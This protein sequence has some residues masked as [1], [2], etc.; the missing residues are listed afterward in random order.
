METPEK[1]EQKEN[2]VSPTKEPKSKEQGILAFRE[3]SFSGPIPPPNFL[4]EYEKIQPGLADRLVKLAEN[5]AAHRQEI[6]KKVIEANCRNEET[7]IKL[8]FVLT[9]AAVIIGAFLIWSNKDIAGWI[10]LFGVLG[11]QGINYYNFKKE[12]EKDTD[13]YKK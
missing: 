13:S 7:G 9:L 12:E 5:Q 4:A 11:F 10:T 1:I 8:A 2:P 6:E 3:E